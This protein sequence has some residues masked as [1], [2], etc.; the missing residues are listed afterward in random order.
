MPKGNHRNRQ[1]ELLAGLAAYEAQFGPL[2]GIVGPAA[3]ATLVD[4]MISSLRRIDFVRG[5]RYRPIMSPERIDPYSSLFDPLKGAYYLG[6]K[7]ARDEAIWIAF[8]G[9]HFGKHARDGWKLAANVMGSFGQGP[10]WT[11]KQYGA[12]TAQF[13]AMLAAHEADLKSKA[14]SGRFSNH[15]QYQS[16]KVEKIALVF[17][18]FHEWLTGFDGIDARVRLIHK[19]VGQN[20]TAVFKELYRSMKEVYGF[21]RLGNFD[22]L[23]MVGKLDLAPIEADSVHFTGAT[24]PLSG[25]K[26]LILGDKDANGQ[27]KAIETAVDTLDNYLNV[28]KQVLEDSLCNWQKSP[29]VYVYFRG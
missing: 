23:T 28:G 1:A 3:R 24:G 10:V 4:Q 17:S 7:G 27:T 18:T 15:R 22:F 14:I 12:H 25:A 8:I 2:P 6:R 20:P 9:T 16:K 13:E 19:S 21:G 5:F 29:T 11:L 26:L